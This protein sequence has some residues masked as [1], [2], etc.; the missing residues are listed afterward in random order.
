MRR[1]FGSEYFLFYFL[2][3]VRE[4][5]WLIQL[6]RKNYVAESVQQVV[7]DFVD[8][9]V[10]LSVFLVVMG[11]E[12]LYEVLATRRNDEFAVLKHLVDKKDSSS[13]RGEF[14]VKFRQ[15][16]NRNRLQSK[17]LKFQSFSRCCG[18]P[19]GIFEVV[20]S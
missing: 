13:P 2:L 4:L 20:S 19:N 1:E 7:I 3:T 5:S 11:L 9:T 15:F 17:V 6:Q 14:V 16:L 8:F 10:F 18:V 12:F